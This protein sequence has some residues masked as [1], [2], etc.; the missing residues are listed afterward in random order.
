MPSECL[1]LCYGFTPEQIL[2]HCDWEDVV[3]TTWI[4]CNCP[5]PVEGQGVCVAITYYLGDSTNFISDS[6][7]FESE[8][9][10]L[11]YGFSPDDLIQDCDG[12]E[13]D[14]HFLAKNKDVSSENEIVSY[15]NP[16]T[17]EFTISNE[18]VRNGQI[19]IISIDGRK[20]LSDK[21]DQT[22]TIDGSAFNPGIY[23][24]TIT[25]SNVNITKRVIKM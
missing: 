12:S 24:V 14:S 10:A 5:E 2:V 8:C 3:D 11:C 20:V 18:S 13:A 21:F 1:A 17:N 19:T 25:G 23:I 16:F 22:K 6:L 4:N 7:W 9:L 15:P